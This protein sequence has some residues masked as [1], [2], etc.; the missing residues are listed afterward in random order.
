MRRPRALKRLEPYQIRPVIQM[1]VAHLILAWSIPIT[2]IPHNVQLHNTAACPSGWTA[3]A[4]RCYKFIDTARTTPLGCVQYCG[5]NASL[6]CIRSAEENA[7]VTALAGGLFSWIGVYQR[8][9]SPEPAGGWNVCASGAS[10]N[11]TYWA[12]EQPNEYLGR[13]QDCIAIYPSGGWNDYG[14][15]EE[16]E[17]H[18]CLCEYGAGPSPEYLTFLETQQQARGIVLDRLRTLAALLFGAIVPAIWLFPALLVLG[19]RMYRRLARRGTPNLAPDAAAPSASAPITSAALDAAEKAAEARHAR[20]SFTTAQLGWMLLVVSIAPYSSTYVFATV[21]EPIVGSH[22]YYITARP[23]ATALLLF[24]LR[25]IDAVAIRGLGIFLFC[26]MLF[27]ALLYVSNLSNPNITFGNPFLIAAY[28]LGVLSFTACGALLWPVLVCDR[29]VCPASMR[30]P[31]RRMLLRLWLVGRLFFCGY[32]ALEIPTFL[33]PLYT[34]RHIHP[35]WRANDAQTGYLAIIASNLVAALVLTPANRGRFLRS[36]AAMTSKRGS[37]EQEAASVSALL[38]NRPA[39][40]TLAMAS[41]RFRGLPLSALSL[42]EIMHNKPDPTMY[43]KTVQATLGSV[44]AFASHSWSD[45]GDA[46]FDKLHAWAG[47]EDKLL[48]LDKACIDQLN[49]ADSLACLPVFLSGC[50]QL[51]VL[52]GPTYASR[53]WCVMELYVFVR[54]GGQRADIV[55]ELL[56]DAT[57]D[58]TTSLA[59][60]DAGKARCYLDRD[61][62]GLLAVIESSFGTFA[63]FNKLVRGIFSKELNPLNM[64]VKQATRA[65]LSATDHDVSAQNAEGKSSTRQQVVE[66]NSSFK[67]AMARNQTPIIIEYSA[68]FD[69]KA[70]A[71]LAV[72]VADI[73]MQ[74]Q[75]AAEGLAEQSEGGTVVRQPRV[76]DHPTSITDWQAKL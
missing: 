29:C 34:G 76:V 69:G 39:A 36:I 52:A 40:A 12:P 74:A 58:L 73:E 30:M 1:R 33:S 42:A 56:G 57:A 51:F 24:T 54:M 50:K 75:P 6:A 18:P 65:V 5:V 26:L 19:Y 55:V 14:C 4:G 49:I 8:P 9:G 68:P 7:V 41:E 28:A 13:A 35:T 31:A 62:Q 46:K 47:D 22:T 66:S 61:R 21:L 67:K 38:S 45:P 72:G 70:P 10:N 15:A 59:Q 44:H 48:W 3:G 63:P 43:A 17:L 2:G 27:F 37:R 32:A 11:F 60:F 64:L 25:P 20:V 23:W 53:L 16:S 71:A